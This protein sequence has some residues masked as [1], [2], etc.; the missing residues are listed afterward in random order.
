MSIW[1]NDSGRFMTGFLI[2]RLY[3]VLYF[4]S[5]F[6][7]GNGNEGGKCSKNPCGI[8]MLCALLVIAD[9]LQ[10]HILIEHGRCFVI[11]LAEA[12]LERSDSLSFLTCIWDNIFDWLKPIFHI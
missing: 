4:V 7:M 5:A 10:I 1:Q 2:Y 3:V 12:C 11:T 8:E 6:L 9:A